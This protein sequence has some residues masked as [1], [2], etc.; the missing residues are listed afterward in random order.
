MRQHRASGTGTKSSLRF[1]S[2]LIIAIAGTL[3]ASFPTAFAQSESS[4]DLASRVQQLTDAMNATQA[5]L[6]KSQHELE[7]LRTQ[8]ASLRGELSSFRS[9]EESSSS[10][11][12]LSAAVEQIREQQSVQEAQI[13]TH[14]Q[15]KVETESK[16][17]LKLSGLVLLNSFV[18]TTGVD[19]P[20][21]PT[22]VLPGSG[23]T[24]ASLR[25]TVI[26]F[27]AR[28]PRLFD[29][30]SHADLRVDF[31]GAGSSSSGAYSYTGGLL[32]LRTAHAALDWTRT[33]AFFALDRTILNPE[34][35]T[36]L[37][38]VAVP[39]LAWSGNLWSWNPQFGVTQDVPIAGSARFRLQAAI[40]DV[41]N[42]PQIYASNV[43]APQGVTRP[44]TNEMSRWPGVESRVAILSG[45]ESS[46]V[47]IGAGG[48]FV[49]HR[50]PGGTRFNSWAG[51]VDYR[52]PLPGRAQ[53]SGNAYWGQAL[54]GLGGGAYKDYVFSYSPLT[55]YAFRALDAMGGWAQLTEHVSERFE[56]NAA[57]GTDQVPASQLRPF[58]GD[59]AQ[60]YL[61]QAR[62]RTYT[63]NVIYRPS[64]YLMFSMEYRHIQSSPVVEY[65]TSGDVIG[66]ATGY[67]F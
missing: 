26:G 37:T 31:Y 9:V 30:R 15:S 14:E 4:T 43:T 8:L 57:F 20:I 52:I 38:A 62:N 13:A 28:G 23:S 29:A 53:F 67:R 36:S 66:L 49:P 45:A 11:A 55:G 33:Q 63:A 56:A 39:A 44:D 58:A 51:T 3:C 22:I 60:Y 21:A 46:G 41:M 7:E 27:D 42:P 2:G 1:K 48:L 25:Q 54:G 17:P 32:R 35:P 50:T 24:G 34:T 61:N 47:Q 5:A 18:N 19:D 59:A 64:A 16:Y 6:E 65:T 40:T 12:E 10:A